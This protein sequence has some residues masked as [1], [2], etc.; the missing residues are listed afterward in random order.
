MI[1]LLFESYMRKRGSERFIEHS[2]D[3]INATVNCF[4]KKI[5]NFVDYI[6]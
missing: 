1:E 3:F 6:E 4:K 5:K 2:A